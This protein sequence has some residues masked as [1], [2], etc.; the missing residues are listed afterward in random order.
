MGGA[1]KNACAGAFVGIR[2]RQRMRAPR[3]GVAAST[4][5]E[6]WHKHA[7]A[8]AVHSL[9]LHCQARA[10]LAVC[11]GMFEVLLGAGCSAAAA[12][13]LSCYLNRL[14]CPKPWSPVEAWGHNGGLDQHDQ[15]LVI[16]SNLFLQ[17]RRAREGRQGGRHKHVSDCGGH[18]RAAKA[19]TA[20]QG[21][22]MRCNLVGGSTCSSAGRPPGGSST[23]SL[24]DPGGYRC[25]WQLNSHKV[26]PDTACLRACHNCMHLHCL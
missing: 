26:Q 5:A 6:G 14:F 3:L 24:V 12:L 9:V 10:Q 13:Q 22:W 7:L 16:L 25:R 1:Q 8:G 21:L 19:F 11:V 15:L 20:G 17:K 18:K 2:Q 4:G 23:S